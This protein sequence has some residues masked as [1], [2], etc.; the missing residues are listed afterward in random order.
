M[1]RHGALLLGTTLTAMACAPK[2][3][4]PA[5]E[6]AIEAVL[7]RQRDAWNAGD[8]EGF[9]DGY[10]RGEA[11]IFTSGG[12]IRRG[13]EVTLAG[14]EQ[15]YPDAAAMGTLDFRDIEIRGLGPDS[16]VALG[17]WELSDTPKAGGGVFTLV[18]FRAQD[19]WRIVHDHTSAASSEAP[20]D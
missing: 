14:Y 10:A 8:I 4:S 2:P 17:L 5:D 7:V 20:S 19:H 11:T 3:F 9:M 18:F 6:Q 15:R 16:A 13:F 12:N 1:L